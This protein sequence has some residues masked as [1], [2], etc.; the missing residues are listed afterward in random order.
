VYVGN[1]GDYVK[2]VDPLF[3]P[4]RRVAKDRLVKYWHHEAIITQLNPFADYPA[5]VRRTW[6]FMMCASFVMLASA[7]A[8]TYVRWR[9]E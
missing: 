5:K 7:A 4:F 8:L 3:Q 2:L 6:N 9:R 1:E